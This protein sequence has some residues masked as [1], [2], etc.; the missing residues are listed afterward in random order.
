MTNRFRV[1]DGEDMQFPDTDTRLVL[2]QNEGWELRRLVGS[3]PASG[4]DYVGDVIA[5]SSWPS[6]ALMQCT[7]IDDSEGGPIYEGDLV[8]SNGFQGMPIRG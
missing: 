6:S 5:S 3:E 7:G 2:D 1:W 4:W 8:E